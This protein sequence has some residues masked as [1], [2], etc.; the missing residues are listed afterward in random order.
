MQG[1]IKNKKDS[2]IDKSFFHKIAP[3]V[4]KS[5]RLAAN[6]KAKHPI[7]F[8]QLSVPFSTINDVIAKNLASS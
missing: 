1:I 8:V 3:L 2:R 4:K 5:R 7:I 6:L